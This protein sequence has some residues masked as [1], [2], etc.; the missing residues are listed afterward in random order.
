M[1]Y[2]EYSRREHNPHRVAAKLTTSCRQQGCEFELHV[3]ERLRTKN[4]TQKL[5]FNSFS[6]FIGQEFFLFWGF[7]ET[8]QQ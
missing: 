7:D 3:L 6:E 4:A 2:T 5:K 8:V 1:P